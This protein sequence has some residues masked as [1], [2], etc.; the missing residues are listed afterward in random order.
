MGYHLVGHLVSGRVPQPVGNALPYIVPYQAFRTADGEITVA[1][2]NDR[3]WQDFCAAIERPELGQDRRFA[4]NG[5]R[6]RRRAILAP[7]L[8]AEF[9]TRPAEEWLARL[10]AHNIPAGPINTVDRVARHPQTQARQLLVEVEHPAGRVPLPTAP[11]RVGLPDARRPL[12]APAP[13]PL[14]GQHSEEVLCELLG[15]APAEVARLARDGVVGWRRRSC[16]EA[17]PP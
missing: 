12:P 16:A 15:L 3:M 4:T 13:P 9:L 5:D 14:L 10:Q 6:V 7:L 1:V 2:N 17:T 8:E 11:W